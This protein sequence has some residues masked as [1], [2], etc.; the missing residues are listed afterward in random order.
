MQSLINTVI[1]ETGGLDR[2]WVLNEADLLKI[3]DVTLTYYTYILCFS[4]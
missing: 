4:L 3:I 1:A 2:A